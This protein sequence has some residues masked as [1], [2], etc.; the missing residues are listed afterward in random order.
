MLSSGQRTIVPG[1]SIPAQ[2]RVPTV[3]LGAMV[4][5]EAGVPGAGSEPMLA[6][7][8]AFGVSMDPVPEPRVP[9]NALFAPDTAP[10][11][12]RWGR[13]LP[14]IETLW[15]EMSA[16][17]GR[18]RRQW[19]WSAR[20]IVVGPFFLMGFA[21]IPGAGGLSRIGVASRPLKLH[22]RPEDDGLAPL[23]FTNVRRAIADD[24]YRYLRISGL[25]PAAARAYIVDLAGHVDFGI[26]GTLE[27]LPSALMAL[28]RSGLS[29]AAARHYVA[30]MAALAG[31]GMAAACERLPAL[32]TLFTKSGRSP[33]VAR[34]TLL[35]IAGKAGFRTGDAF[36]QIP[37][38][39]KG[40]TQSGLSAEVAR[41]FL[42]TVA[43]H[44]GQDTSVA[45][46]YLPAAFAALTRS[47]FS[48]AMAQDTLMT[49]AQNAG[50]RTFEA[51][52]YL[53][54]AF[55]ALTGSGLSPAVARGTLIELIDLAGH[56]DHGIGRALDGLPGAFR[57]LTQSGMWPAIARGIL[58]TVART[59]GAAS[60]EA[61]G[62]FSAAFEALIK[63][64]ASPEV[65]RATILTLVEKS[66]EN[67]GDAFRVLPFVLTTLIESGH[68]PEVAGD[69][70]VAIAGKAGIYTD[71]A[72]HVVYASLR[73]LDRRSAALNYREE[74]GI[75]V[76]RLLDI[77]PGRDHGLAMGEWALL[78]SWCFDAKMHPSVYL[79]YMKLIR[80][81]FERYPEVGVNVLVGLREGLDKKIL[82][83]REAPELDAVLAFIGR[84]HG[85]DAAPYLDYRER[86]RRSPLS[87]LP[88][89]IFRS[90]EK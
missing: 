61:L 66:G 34:E 6:P 64:G 84:T 20:M 28:A 23:T 65:A 36:G 67:T 18:A 16:F 25:S 47:D 46:E 22:H 76:D 8:D 53:P 43:D 29:P 89:A 86:R 51:Y 14:A 17:L 21:G 42:L 31:F 88:P 70:L 50:P 81:V 59:A 27:H 60:G 37:A 39:F 73:L 80:A 4:P 32:L 5:V 90:G 87:L 74:L 33:E 58:L 24:A 35:A 56:V 41:V 49:I 75:H 63:S 78:A 48:P 1:V 83:K 55:E 12:I 85:F 11:G 62:Q 79:D 3:T 13:F 69:I 77:L 71:L 52:R 72:F 30:T 9:R 40:L 82:S 54:Y 68:S 15:E 2:L 7:G 26:G 44:A 19:G 38:V 57:A 10:E 45:L